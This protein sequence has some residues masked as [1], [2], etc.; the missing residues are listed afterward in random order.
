VDI[1]ACGKD[2]SSLDE[3]S[4][5]SEEV[6]VELMLDSVLML[7]HLRKSTIH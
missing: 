5:Y 3:V 6:N 2:S 4:I 1:L 7:V